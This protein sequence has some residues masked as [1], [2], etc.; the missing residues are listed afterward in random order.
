MEEINSARKSNEAS[1]P[2]RRDKTTDEDV[3]EKITKEFLLNKKQHAFGLSDYMRT[4]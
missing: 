2:K 1:P 4:Q 3:G